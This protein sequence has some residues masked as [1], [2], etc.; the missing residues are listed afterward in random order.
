MRIARPMRPVA[1]AGSTPHSGA[2]PT[3]ELRSPQLLANSVCSCATQQKRARR[4]VLHT[5]KHAG[6]KRQHS[7]EFHDL[8]DFLRTPC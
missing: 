6:G 8:A 5:D 2:A 4:K 7:G 3:P 1:S